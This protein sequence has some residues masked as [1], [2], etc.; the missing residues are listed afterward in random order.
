MLSI[1]LDF[2]AILLLNSLKIFVLLHMKIK[3]I[4]NHTFNLSLKFPSH[5]G[6]C[7]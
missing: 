4:Y 7:S 6:G 2:L 5:Y 3:S 1:L